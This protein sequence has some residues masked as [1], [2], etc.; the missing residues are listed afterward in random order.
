V[1]QQGVPQPNGCGTL[2]L[3]LT[4]SDSRPAC[5]HQGF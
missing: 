5:P 2:S 1:V 3:Q 4:A